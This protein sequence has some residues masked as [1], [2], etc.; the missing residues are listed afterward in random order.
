M[1]RAAS[2]CR[3]RGSQPARLLI[4]VPHGAT[5]ASDYARFAALIKSPL[6]A[7]LDHFFHVNTDEGAPEGAI[8]I[9]DALGQRGIGVVV[10]RCTIP[11]TFIDTNRVVD[12]AASG[13]KIVDGL[14]PGLPG[15]ITDR[16]D[17]AA[18]TAMHERYHAEVAQLYAEVCGGGGLALQLHS[19]A[20][21]SVG[22]E[23]TD[24][25]I[26]GALHA[27]Y[28]AD[29]YATWPE[30]PPV[31]IICATADGAFRCNPQLVEAVRAAYASA[32]IRAGENATYHLHPITM[33]FHYA[34]AYPDRVVCVELDRGEVADPFVPFAEFAD[35]PDQG[36]AHDRAA[37]QRARR[38][39][40]SALISRGWIHVITRSSARNTS[41]WSSTGFIQPVVMQY[42]RSNGAV[43]WRR[44]CSGDR[45]NRQRCSARTHCGGEGA[46]AHWW[47]W[48]VTS[49]NTTIVTT[50][51][52]G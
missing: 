29:V 17:G 11:R 10:A 28:A 30:R 32:Q 48:L 7:E 16:D 44:W 4:E 15:Y 25:N 39:A 6:P 34:R 51:A 9:A 20:P 45:I 3:R 21:R 52:H 50:S 22:V 18:L 46:C 5:R 40:V 1:E 43:W 26:V 27:A 24:A 37:G 47:I 8:A 42:A 23:A 49:A 36:R 41:R 19:Y 12:A 38:C 35:Q 13:G 31:D 14:T 33:G 2:S